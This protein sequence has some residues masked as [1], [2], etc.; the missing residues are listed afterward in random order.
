MGHAV[1]EHFTSHLPP[2]APRIEIDSA[3][4]GAYHVLSPPD[5]RTMATLRAHGIRNFSHA[6]RKVAADDFKTFDYIFAMDSENLSD[7]KYKRQRLISNGTLNSSDAEENVTLFGDWDPIRKPNG[8]RRG[9][10][11]EDPYYGGDEGFETAFRQCVRFSQG[12]IREVLSF[13]V[14]IDSKG[15]V[16]VKEIPGKSQDA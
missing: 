11:V 13:D 16:T 4:T 1:L 9:E 5:P 15:K 10:E 8:R 12:W 6:A 2:H 7:L 14:D 3:G